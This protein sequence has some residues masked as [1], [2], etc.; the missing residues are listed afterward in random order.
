MVAPSFGQR[1]LLNLHAGE[2]TAHKHNEQSIQDRYSKLILP[3][4]NSEYPAVSTD[5]RDQCSGT[6][7]TCKSALPFSLLYAPSLKHT[8]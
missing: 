2:L 4:P 8:C 1:P 7:C 3:S 5:N 6:N